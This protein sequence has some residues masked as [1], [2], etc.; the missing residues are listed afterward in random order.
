MT[1]FVYLPNFKRDFYKEQLS[2]FVT[3]YFEKLSP[4]FDKIEEEATKK[5]EEEYERIGMNFD[6]DRSDPAEMAQQAED[7]GQRYW[8]NSNLMRYNTKLMTISTFYQIWEQQVRKLLYE[9]LTRHHSLIDK[10]GNEIS[11]SKFGTR[12]I[13]Q[14]KE[15]F[16]QCGVVL[17]QLTSWGK[18]DELRLLQNVIKHGDGKAAE[19]LEGIRPTYFRR[20]GNTKVMDLYLTTLGDLVLDV[21]DDELN[22]YLDSLLE[23]WDD[24]PERMY[25]NP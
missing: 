9:E 7:F 21:D 13:D 10:H 14:I 6:P 16:S 18:I 11:F 3:T 25:F 5:A 22:I 12:G 1:A 23:F 19:K 17:E 15:V 20:V 24:L 2:T 8:E 4:V